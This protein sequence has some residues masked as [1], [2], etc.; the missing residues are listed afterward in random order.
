[1][2]KKN[3]ACPPKTTTYLYIPYAQNTKSSK[4]CHKQANRQI[5]IILLV[6]T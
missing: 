4:S 1:M 6:F 5:P 2:K 3:N